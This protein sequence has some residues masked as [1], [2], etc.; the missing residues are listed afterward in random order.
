[1]TELCEKEVEFVL[2]YDGPQNPFGP[3]NRHIKGV[4]NVIDF[5]MTAASGAPDAI[6]SIV[7]DV[8]GFVHKV[9][10]EKFISCKLMVDMT[11]VLKVV[12]TSD[13][14]AVNNRNDASTESKGM[15][16]DLTSDS[17]SVI[18]SRDSLDSIPSYTAPSNNEDIPSSRSGDSVDSLSSAFSNFALAPVTAPVKCYHCAQ[19]SAEINTQGKVTRICS[20]FYVTF[21]HPTEFLEIARP[22]GARK[23]PTAQPPVAERVKT[24]SIR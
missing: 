24:T 7:G 17:D 20:L 10:G 3:N 4:D 6:F 5:N 21:E 1:M 19:Y 14:S 23:K 18:G 13:S 12:A 15:G 16:I 22:R 8:K 9:T 2:E 11:I